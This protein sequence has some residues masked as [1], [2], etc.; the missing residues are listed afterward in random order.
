MIDR[1]KALAL[2]EK[3]AVV[4]NTIGGHPFENPDIAKLASP[5]D[6]AAMAADADLFEACMAA[7]DALLEFLN[8]GGK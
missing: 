5:K 4:I 3:L 1:I 2:E 6:R 8:E 7:R